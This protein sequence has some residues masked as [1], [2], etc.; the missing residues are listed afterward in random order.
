MR[1]LGEGLFGPGNVDV[2]RGEEAVPGRGVAE[3]V[4]GCVALD[5]L[6][7][8]Y[9]AGNASERI[10]KGIDEADGGKRKRR[11]GGVEA[12]SAVCLSAGGYSDVDLVVII[13]W[14]LRYMMFPLTAALTQQYLQ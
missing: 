9:V 7:E 14:L 8:N 3:G 5:E 2:L 1:G 4:V 6:G 12:A 10:G 13:S 11:F